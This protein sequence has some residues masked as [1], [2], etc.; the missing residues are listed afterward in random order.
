MQRGEPGEALDCDVPARGADGQSVGDEVL[1][2]DAAEP[3]QAMI[4]QPRRARLEPQNCA[5]AVGEA[6]GD[7]RLGERKPLHDIGDGSALGAL[8]FH[9]LEPRRR[10]IEQIAHLDARA[11]ADRRGLE[12]RLATAIDG[13][14]IGFCRRRGR[15]S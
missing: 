15:G 3:R 6:E 7:L 11:A 13:D 12:R 8:G 2:E 10:R 4:E 14:L 5:V 1:A 9:E